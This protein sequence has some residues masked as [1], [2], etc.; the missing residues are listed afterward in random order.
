MAE[1]VLIVED[2]S[3][4]AQAIAYTLSQEGFEA[5]IASDG[6][7]ALDAFDHHADRAHRGSGPRRGPR[8]GR[9]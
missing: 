7:E 3:S 2:E 8:D 1:K 5:E 4:V 6:R 9:R